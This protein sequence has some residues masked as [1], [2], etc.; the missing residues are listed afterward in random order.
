MIAY[1][2]W[3][4]EPNGL[5]FAVEHKDKNHETREDLTRIWK[6]CPYCGKSLAIE[7]ISREDRTRTLLKKQ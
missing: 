7:L 6:Y 3:K 1:C 2:K 4:R 5:Y